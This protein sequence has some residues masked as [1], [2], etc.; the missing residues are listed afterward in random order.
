MTTDE[1]KTALAGAIEDAVRA[2]PGVTN[3]FRSGTLVGKAMT[4]AA[5]RLGLLG[6]DSPLV[7]LEFEADGARVEVSVGVGV[8]S[9]AA[10]AV[11]AVRAAIERT[12]A[13]EAVAMSSARVTVVHIQS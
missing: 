11:R 5:E 8:T 3:V 10:T 12:L 4:A 9:P 2:V 7:I 6:S 13:A 1:Q